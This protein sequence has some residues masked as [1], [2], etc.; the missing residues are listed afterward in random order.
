MADKSS[1]NITRMQFLALESDDVS[2][3]VLELLKVVNAVRSISTP[4][5]GEIA[6]IIEAVN[7]LTVA[8]NNSAQN[9]QEMLKTTSNK[10]FETST[11]DAL[12]ATNRQLASILDAV[13]ASA[14]ASNKK[15][16]GVAPKS[17]D[18]NDETPKE[19]SKG[20]KGGGDGI[21]LGMTVFIVVAS[22]I[23]GACAVIMALKFGLF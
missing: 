9:I 22:N 20:G 23:V 1:L 17:A 15:E 2:L 3:Q 12:D 4:D 10:S 5:I 11:K 21:G 8:L 18:V 13:R 19:G 14:G 6:K 7:K 16:I